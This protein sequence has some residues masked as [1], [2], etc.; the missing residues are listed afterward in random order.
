MSGK[1]KQYQ[2]KRDFKETKEPK[3]K[4]RKTKKQLNF[5]IHHHMASREHYD[6]RLELDGTLKSWAVP[7]GPSF[8]PSDKR[9]AVEVEDHPFQYRNFEGTIP[10]GQYG[11]G[12]VMIWDEGIWIPI[13]IKE[14]SIKFTLEGNRLKGNWSLVRM[15]DNN[16]LIIKEK[17]AFSQ[18]TD[19]IKKYTTSIRTGRT[20]KEIEDEN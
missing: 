14:N 13:E 18:K 7:K 4:V 5:V 19:G 1:L 10:Q 11:G 6:L 16:W 15:K 12:T 3:G 2:E 9:L 20:M 8:N 17:D